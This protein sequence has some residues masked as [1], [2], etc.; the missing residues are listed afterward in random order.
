MAKRVWGVL[1]ARR[2]TRQEIVSLLISREKRR[3]RRR[4]RSLSHATLAISSTM[5]AVGKA[6]I[7]ARGDIASSASISATASKASN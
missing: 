2:F 3:K 1:P 5:T 4:G 7:A 6:F